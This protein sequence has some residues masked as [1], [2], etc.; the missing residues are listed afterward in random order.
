M[1]GENVQ[2]WST[3]AATNSAADSSIGWA[4]GQNPSTVNNSARSMMAATAKWC[5]LLNGSKTTGGS[6]NAQTLS[7]GVGFSSLP[8]GL[9]IRVKIGFTNTAS[10]TLNV[11]SIGGVT[12]KDQS[13]NNLAGG[14]LL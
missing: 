11:D 6:G 9:C 10:T 1:A 13:G 5:D 2:D 12:I 14:E 4:E 7:S 3:T 8:T